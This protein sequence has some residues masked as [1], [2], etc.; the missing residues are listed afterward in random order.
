MALVGHVELTKMPKLLESQN[1]MKNN[2]NKSENSFLSS[3]SF[4]FLFSFSFLFL[5]LFLDFTIASL[6]HHSS[7]YFQN[8]AVR[9][10]PFNNI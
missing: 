6:G 1:K 9:N 5:F 3:F 8:I 10:E 4:L 2:E 7:V